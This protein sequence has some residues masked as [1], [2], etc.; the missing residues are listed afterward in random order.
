MNIRSLMRHT[1][2]ISALCAFLG[3]PTVAYSAAVFLVGDGYQN[4]SESF[5]LTATPPSIVNPVGA[6]GFTG[7]IGP[8]P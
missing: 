5:T 6:G 1:V 8:N 7:W 4:G 3:V 2:L